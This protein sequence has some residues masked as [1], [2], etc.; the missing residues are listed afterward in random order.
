MGIIDIQRARSQLMAQT[1][2]AHH[3]QTAR[4]DKHHTLD[5]AT[6]QAWLIACLAELMSID[7]ATINIHDSFASYG[8]ASIDAISFSGMLEDCFGLTLPDSILYD[9][10]TINALSR[11]LC[12]DEAE[13][14]RPSTDALPS[15]IAQ[16]PL[17][18]EPIAIVGIACRFPGGANTAEAFWQLLTEGRDAVSE[19][20]STRW[21]SDQFYD[22]DPQTPGKMYTRAGGFL[23]EIDSFDAR[24]FGISPREALHMEPQQRLLLELAWEAFE[25]AGIAVETLAGS[26]TG[27]FIGMIGN[28]GYAR[29]QEQQADTSYVDDPYYGLGI[30]PSIAAGRISYQFDLRGPNLTLDTACSS[31]LVALHLACQS[32]QND[33]CQLALV[34]GVNAILHPDSMVNLCKMNM[35][36]TT[37]RCNTFDAEA[38]GFAFGEGCGMI[39]LKRHSEAIQAGDTIF[40]LIR[41]SALNQDGKSNGITA[42]NRLAQ[43]QVVRDALRNAHLAPEQ[44]GYVEAHGSGTALGDP[45]EI[46][47]LESIFAPGRQ[48]DQR[49][50]VGSVKTNIGHLAGAAGIAGLIKTVLALYHK[51][52]PAH[53][54]LQK[55]N[56]NLAAAFEQGLAIPQTLT[57]W[58]SGQE[59]RRAGVSSFGWSGTNAHVVLEEA[60][61]SQKPTASTHTRPWQCL[62]LSAKS[63]KALADRMQDLAAYLREHPQVALADVSYTCNTGRSRLDYQHTV[64]YQTREEAIALLENY[65]PAQGQGHASPSRQRPITFL[66][67]GVGEQYPGMTRGLYEH[68]PAFRAAVDRCAELLMPH[69][70]ADLREILYPSNDPSSTPQADGPSGLDLRAMLGRGKRT[71]QQD[72]ATERLKQTIF[73][74]PAVFV[75]E[76]AL[77]QLLQQWGLTPKAMLG[78]SL[79]EYVAACLAGVISLEDA[80]F[81]VAR[82]AALIDELP[83][84]AMLAVSLSEQD[85]TQYLDHNLDLA[86]TS[87]PMMSVIAGPL[88]AIERLECQLQ[89]QEIVCMR[90]ETTHAFHS[91][92]LKPIGPA[93]HAL[94]QG[95]RLSAP[96]IPYISDLSGTWITEQEATD[97]A[98]WVRQMCQTV[99]FSQGIRQIVQ[100]HPT[101]IF[102]EIGPGQG[103]SSL[104][105]LSPV[106]QGEQRAAIFSTIRPAYERKAD[107]AYLLETLGNLWLAGGKIDWQGFYREEVRQRL[108]LPTY[109]FERQ[110][111]WITPTHR[112]TTPTSAPKAKKTDRSAW[113]YRP[114]WETAP[115][116]RKGKRKATEGPILILLDQIG[117]GEQIAQRLEH[118]G[119]QI[120]RVHLADDYRQRDAKSFDLP[121]HSDE[122]YSL[123]FTDLHNQHL[124]PSQ[125]IHC[126]S[127]TSAEKAKSSDRA[128]FERMQ[129]K[130]LYSLL[131][132]TRALAQHQHT[133]N[134]ELIV[135][136]NHLY[137]IDQQDIVS[138]EKAT[139]AGACKVIVQEYP[140]LRTRCL[141]PGTCQI[142]DLDAIATEVMEGEDILEVAYRT[143]KRSVQRFLPLRLEHTSHSRLR[144]QGVYLLTGGLGGIGLHLAESLAQQVQAKLIL[145]GRNGLPPQTAWEQ[146][147]QEHGE[148]ESISRCI[149]AVQRMEAHGAE[150]CI[151]RADVADEQQMSQVLHTIDQ[152]FGHL[153][154]VVHC[155]GYMT[156]D[157]FRSIQQLRTEDCERHFQPKVYGLYVM[158]QV[159]RDRQLD[160]CMIFSSISSILGG[161]GFCAYTAANAF[162]DAFVCEH[163]RSSAQPW[164]RVNWD[165]WLVSSVTKQGLSIEG[166]MAQ[167][168]MSPQEG[169][170][171]F[172][173]ILAGDTLQVVN[174]TGDLQSR[175][176]QWLYF[177]TE[178][179]PTSAESTYTASPRA[180]SSPQ[181]SLSTDDLE[182]RLAAIWQNVLGLEQV[183]LY[184]NF[185]DLGGNSFIGLHLIAKMR[186]ELQVQLSVVALFEAPTIH[187]MAQY[188]RPRQES[189]QQESSLKWQERRKQARL[190]T[191]DNDIAIVGMTGRFPGANT[192][193]QFWQNLVQ[194]RESITFFQEQDLLM[195]GLEPEV[196]AL[197]NYVKARPVLDDVAGFDATLFGYSPRE[198]ELMDPQH[199]LFLECCWEV[200][201]LAGYDPSTYAGLIG[202]F[203][204]SNI[205]TYLLSML[206]SPEIARQLNMYQMVI[207][208]DKDALTTTVSYKLDLKGPSFAVQTFCSTSLVAIHLASQSLLHGECDLALAGGVSIRVPTVI[209]HLYEEGGMESPD[210]HCRTFDAQARGSIFGDGVG[211]VVL[212]R[213]TDALEDGDT[214]HAVL[215]G[216]AINN[217]GSLKVSY[218][219]PSVVG[220]AEAVKAALEQGGIDAE[221]IQYI[222]AHGTATVLGD[223][224]EVAS[225]TK[226]FRHYTQQKQYCAIGSVKTNVGHLDRA[227]GVS[228]LIK[229]VESLKHRQIPASL[230][231][232]EPNPAIDFANSPFYVNA[233]LAEWPQNVQGTPRRAGINSL[234]MGG[235]NV[236]VIVEEAPVQEKGQRDEQGRREQLFVLSARTESALEAISTNLTAY[237]QQHEETDLGDIAYTLQVGRKSLDHRRII[238]CDSHAQA[239]KALESRDPASI[240]DAVQTQ[241]DR[242]IAFLFSGVGEHYVGMAQELYQRE[243]IFRE[244]IDFCCELLYPHLGRDL[245]ELLWPKEVAPT[246]GGTGLD[247]RAM[248]RRGQTEQQSEE[249]RLLKQTRYAQPAVFVI[250]YA[251]SLLLRRWGI[252]PQAMLGY[253]LGEYVAA[254]V[255]GVFTLEEALLLVSRRAA[256]I[257]AL[258]TGA[259]LAVSLSAEEVQPYLSEDVSLAVSSGPNMS[260]L[261]GSFQGIENIRRRLEQIK[262]F[263]QPV[264][265]THAFHSKQMEAAAEGLREV[266]KGIRLRDP[267]VAYLS[268]V[269]GTWITGQEA[270]D[271]E[272]WIRHMCQTVRF[273]EGLQQLAERDPRPIL[274]EIGVGQAMSSLVKQ[275]GDWRRQDVLPTLRASYERQPEESYLLRT[276]GRI[277]LEG[278][279][280]DW[281]AF[282]G[283][284]RRR[285]I[286]LPTYPFERQY[287]WTKTKTLNSTFS[288]RAGQDFA[289]F[290]QA[291]KN[292]QKESLENWYYLPAW[293]RAVPLAPHETNPLQPQTWLF[294]TDESDFARSLQQK[295][296]Q[297]GQDIILLKTG[298]CFEQLCESVYSIDPRT[299]AHYDT[300]F[301]ALRLQNRSPKRILH[302]WTLTADGSVPL[303]LQLVAETLEKGF[304]SLLYLAQA[305]GDS[306]L[307]DCQI[308][309][310]SNDMHSVTGSEQ[311]HA[312]KA[313]LLGPCRVIPLEYP[314]L[315]CRNIDIT[316]P[317]PQ[318]QAEK[319]LLELLSRELSTP[320]DETVI[321]LRGSHRWLQSYEPVRL[322]AEAPTHRLRH[323]GVYLITGGLGGIGLGMAEYLAR[324]FQA[325]LVLLGRSELPDRQHWAHL[326]ATEDLTKGIGYKLHKMREIEALGA[327]VLTLAADVANEEQ[328]QIAIQQAVAR[329]GTLHG[330][331]HA[332]GVPGIGLMQMKSVEQAAKVLA[333][334]VAGTLILAKVLQGFSLD[335]LVL[336][337]SISSFMGGGPGQVDYCAA[338][339]FLDAFAQVPMTCS[340]YVISINWSEWQWNAWEE[341]L[342]GYDK[343]T[344]QFFRENRRRVGISFEDGAEALRRLL[345]SP[346]AQVIVSPQNFCTF[347]E[348][349]KTLTAASLLKNMQATQPEK[350]PRPALSTSYVAPRNE[351][352]QR[353]VTIWEDLLGTEKI[354][355]HD[356]FF[357][358]GGHSLMGTQLISRLRN[359]FHM[360]LSLSDLF[361]APTI[362]D[363]A[364]AAAQA[365]G[366]EEEDHHPAVLRPISPEK[367]QQQL[368]AYLEGLPEA[369][370]QPV[371]SSI[372]ES[373]EHRT[374]FNTFAVSFAQ[375]RMWVLEQMTPDTAAYINTGGLRLRGNLHRRALEQ[376]VT[377]IVARHE[378]LRTI[379]PAVGGRPVQVVETPP[380]LSLL[381]HDLSHLSRQEREAEVERRAVQEIHHPFDLATGP[382]FRSS[383]LR[384]D[385]EEHILLLSIHHIVFDGWSF[386]ILI[387]E[388]V[389]LY[390]AFAAELPS[391]LPALPLQYADYSQWQREWLEGPVMQEQLAFWHQQLR[392]PLPNL[393]LPT[394]R[395]RPPV[396]TVSGAA[397]HFSLLPAT[398]TAL[399]RLS[400]EEGTTLFMTLLTGFTMLLSRYSGQSDLLVGTPIANR[401]H[402]EVEGLIGCF[403]NTLVLRTDLSNQPSLRELLKRIRKVALDA[404]A[405]QD[406]PFEQ[407]V[408][409]LHPERDLSRSPLF[410]VMFA[411]QNAPQ[412]PLKLKDMTVSML[413]TPLQVA[414]FDLSL[415]M[416]ET[417][418]GLEGY[419]EYNTDLF[420]ESTLARMTQHLQ[421]AFQVLGDHPDQ[422]LSDLILLT[423]EER[424]LALRTWNETKRVF[425]QE[426]ACVHQLIEAQVERTPQAV[427]VTSEEEQLTYRQ[428]NER[429]NQLAHHL[430]HLGVGPEVPVGLCINR[431]AK[432]LVGLLGILKAGGAYVPLDP[433]YPKERLAFILEEMQIPVLLTERQLEQELPT[434]RAQV[435]HIDTDWEIIAQQCM[436]NPQSEV[437]AQNMAYVLYTSGSTGKPKGVM[438]PQE[439]LV[440]LLL[441]MREHLAITEQD[442]MLATTSLSFD[443]AGLELYLP[444]LIGAQIIVASREMVSNGMQLATAIDSSPNPVL[445]MTPAAWRMLLEAGWQGNQQLRMLCGGEALPLELARTLLTK[446]ANLVNLY[447][448]TETTIWSMLHP[449]AQSDS[450]ISL[451]QPIANTQIYIL[452][453]AMQ[454]VAIGVPGELYIGG[455]GLARGYL[456]RPD[457]TAERFVPHP[458]GEEPGSRLYRT[459]DLVRYQSRYTIEFLGRTDQQIKVHGFRIELGE[460]ETVLS[461]H[462]EVQEVV[463][464]PR[465]DGMG[466]KQLVAYVVTQGEVE[467]KEWRSYLRARLP[468]YMV[469]SVFLRLEALPLTAN[470]KV[471]R[472]ALPTPEKATSEVEYVAPRTPLE[473]QLAQIWVQ[474]LG[475]ERVGVLD[476]FFD[477]GGHSLNATQIASHIQHALGVAMPLRSLFENPTITDLAIIVELALLEQIEMLEE[478]ELEQYL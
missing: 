345:A 300:L 266:L 415:F 129:E 362:A 397:Y 59:P 394:D 386:G 346:F 130:G 143:G 181:T 371:R 75:I 209:G 256:L 319:Q 2:I 476:N 200:L 454:P 449:V 241:R 97:P 47:A 230:H 399:K 279:K 101:P 420:E 303:S 178:Q 192:V 21:E 341:G 114:T 35:L 121:I 69:L 382:L 186:Q 421:R 133:N 245:R 297:L 151:M 457:L 313:T 67:S 282:K 226:A 286:P 379:F 360:N 233:Q 102:L 23:S 202:V 222:E 337:S 215:K 338:N 182:Q 65:A 66:F 175:I 334:K 216:S 473:E 211:V 445:Q 9:Y 38:D 396:Q 322:T 172:E 310:L 296:A 93:L 369:S 326:L 70:K 154:G 407:I 224:I 263:S 255:A 203:A 116:L 323:G 56:P 84:G 146:W 417:A 166:T 91:R 14:E 278:G 195:A 332:A 147:L 440:N 321:A 363:L 142:E 302:L 167:Y 262:L 329:F 177:D 252:Q 242:P 353:M 385:D 460:I 19:I 467:T 404:Y 156:S 237:L 11:F 232:R 284:E 62:T 159:L 271:P 171:A 366:Q 431:S 187:A 162:I 416:W 117:I 33:E 87:G 474:V 127:I 249:A 228:G 168:A 191:A 165:M 198:A 29:L 18:T 355:I 118:Q 64:L 164:T 402:A 466:G 42:P 331:I 139:L 158:E 437:A 422:L 430:R 315:S 391:P 94:L 444:L 134:V 455:T 111:Y 439:A 194:G 347:A 354:G 370:L 145:V 260:V 372:R 176:R 160:F 446:G 137:A 214:I 308:T 316:L 381:P 400:H 462:P 174:S 349:G 267:Q 227:A 61:E 72:E 6:V 132:L 183:G 458:Y 294:L 123:F 335:F 213:L 236:H 240:L 281:E 377:E 152:R 207:G 388:L 327:E 348:I 80:L 441:S 99:R 246:K 10:P 112:S 472:R 235:T 25:H 34:G 193:E 217:D 357:E 126:W 225:L 212:K 73:A 419:F 470:G 244:C 469:P 276:V 464:L 291:I 53:L 144:T 456:N 32:L 125:M 229:V 78:Y 57:P 299:R 320:T 90:V 309:V 408:K 79:G 108:P 37:G 438:I 106:C 259:M 220:Q 39:V 63:E 60:Q 272:Y 136:A 293:K 239:I 424:E 12:Q 31:S 340:N 46:G 312:E 311:L 119:R 425:E 429:A 27:V 436:A 43:E 351:V 324:A 471:D 206:Q 58:Q 199:R 358:L 77:A 238:V 375:Q 86:A 234:G 231:Y 459:G 387:H 131:A 243:A 307:E 352:E 179:Q 453:A 376:A 96:Q 261:S 450:S 343:G 128:S 218:T 105:K 92:M 16:P 138:P 478:E 367:H 380:S 423:V 304:N 287:L 368:L 50:M 409:E 208:N 109:P 298:N 270:R 163:N 161:L 428:L 49:L 288:S 184:E 292:L 115:L 36:S 435:I 257:D 8:L 44:I 434:H 169:I 443:I 204:G 157:A 22:P 251:L 110:R 275:S 48:T 83:T 418:E 107:Q 135:I 330:V 68:E 336:C 54:N 153:D 253:S 265:T 398:T 210:G 188:L 405:H 15:T 122:K 149:L 104:I 384:L 189:Q 395:P 71:G 180:S 98:Y 28:H 55:L 113:F 120:L 390:E 432:M 427:A 170:D 4:S 254:C 247:L 264:E 45:I 280:I 413:E 148:D 219:A 393:D 411:M 201:E 342:E 426:Q 475:V 277:W 373:A 461:Q 76:Y 13:Q 81:L 197:P 95:V 403:I 103:L 5:L 82:R 41:G 150:V 268:N 141:D 248:L 305:I 89:Q 451:G 30:A 100:D 361:E 465:E 205:S 359:L 412:S 52:I 339:A 463:V 314:H 26:K 447:G 140:G 410:Q 250:E 7:P 414:K 452:D 365:L 356:N 383:L 290:D 333:P 88:T 295:L 378:T 1:A 306:G 40:A 124:L 325:K 3:L 448:P 20:P 433:A 344:Q 17:S 477:L 317:C 185:F 173:R 301:K 442:T 155:A 289:S 274:V 318:S 285:R 468:E 389:Q 273:G 401:T 85:V 328:M 364:H 258:P 51:Q 221:T 269:S 190:Q 24:F 196:I 350:Y 74:Q 374:R 392:G 223:P 283:K 406:V